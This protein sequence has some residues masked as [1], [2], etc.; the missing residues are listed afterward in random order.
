[1]SVENFD[2]DGLADQPSIIYGFVR[3]GFE[4][5]ELS[6]SGFAEPGAS[7]GDVLARDSTK[8]T[9]T[10]RLPT[11]DLPG[12]PGRARD[13]CGEDRPAFACDS[14]GRPV[15]VG[16]TCGSPACERCWAAAVKKKLT[17][18]SG[19]LA[20]HK[21][22]QYDRGDGRN[23]DYNHV[24]AS[25]PSVRV[26]SEQPIQRVL[27]I[28][29]EILRRNWGIEDFAWI[30]HERRIKKEYRKDLLDHPG[31]DGEGDM[32]WKDVLTAEEREKYTYYAPH[33]HLFFPAYRRQFDYS[34]SEAVEE[35]TGWLFHRVEDDDNISI[36]DLDD[37]VHQMTYC[38][39][40][41]HVGTN[42]PRTELSTGLKGELH[43][44]DPA[45]SKE[46]EIL[47]SFCAAAPKLLGVQFAN[48]NQATCEA[49]VPVDGDDDQDGAREA[50]RD[51]AGDRPDRDGD[52]EADRADHAGGG[53]GGGGGSGHDPRSLSPSSARE[54]DHPDDWA[55]DLPSRAGQSESTVEAAPGETD[56][57]DGEPDAPAADEV[58][59]CGG[60]LEPMHEAKHLLE[61]AEWCQQAEHVD[62]LQ[63]AVEEYERRREDADEDDE[64]RPWADEGA[65]IEDG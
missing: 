7:P 49:E 21:W 22:L 57:V 65:V 37:L 53:G 14:C 42:G 38:L 43:N 12:S 13:D 36:E 4:I 55:D 52:Q 15:Y 44:L 50:D 51:G 16:R 40:H 62:G 41:A 56:D 33:F 27:K 59:E 28:V 9:L 23:V 64:D 39:S 25:L 35:R 30:Y 3:E 24:I 60:A 17:R 1:M 32:S 46:N 6:Q 63:V 31:E 48:L 26:D 29:Q 5:R 61:D 10:D 19:K 18:Y 11:G 20:R 34:V 2:G 54:F 45:H 8:S 47:S 58:Q